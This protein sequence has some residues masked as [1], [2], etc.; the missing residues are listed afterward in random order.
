MQGEHDVNPIS[1][2]AI[3]DMNNYLKITKRSTEARA[4]NEW[5]WRKPWRRPG[6]AT[7]LFVAIMGRVL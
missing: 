1:Q 4:C 6:L 2:Y 3:Y 7:G 5:M